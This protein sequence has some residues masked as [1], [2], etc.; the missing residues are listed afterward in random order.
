MNNSNTLDNYSSKIYEIL[1]CSENSKKI[2]IEVDDLK[3]KLGIE[4]NKYNITY[5]KNKI[6]IPAQKYINENTNM[7]VDLNYIKESRRIVSIEFIV[8]IKQALC[9]NNNIPFKNIDKFQRNNII[10]QVKNIF[11]SNNLNISRTTAFNLYKT[12]FKYTSCT[13]KL[14]L[15]RLAAIKSNS[16]QLNQVKKQFKNIIKMDQ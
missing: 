3:S 4:E 12:A 7:N 16:T 10:Q 15:L 6:L 8:D 11:K 5:F 14:E 13:D 2:I 1:K 9:K